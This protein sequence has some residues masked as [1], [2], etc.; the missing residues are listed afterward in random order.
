MKPKF[1]VSEILHVTT[2]INQQENNYDE[3]TKKYLLTVKGGIPTVPQVESQA[4]FRTGR[5]FFTPII[6]LY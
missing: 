2:K 6:M 4:G 3:G 1:N 5:I